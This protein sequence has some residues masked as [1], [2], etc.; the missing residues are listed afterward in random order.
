[1]NIEAEK[2]RLRHLKDTLI[3]QKKGADPD[4]WWGT[5]SSSPVF[6]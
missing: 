1:M 5:G 3:R 6:H 4:F 2:D